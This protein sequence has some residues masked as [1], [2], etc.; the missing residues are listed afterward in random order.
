MSSSQDDC[1]N[2]AKWL[3]NLSNFISD[4]YVKYPRTELRGLLQHVLP[5]P[6]FLPL[7]QRLGW[8]QQFGEPRPP[9]LNSQPYTLNP[10]P[11][12]LNPEA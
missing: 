3:L 1:A 10:E 9:T 8:A 5:L 12:P 11:K 7:S 4:T 2:L 6:S